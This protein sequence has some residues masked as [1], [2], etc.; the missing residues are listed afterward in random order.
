MRKG[1]S[2]CHILVI[3][4][5][6]RLTFFCKDHRD[7]VHIGDSGGNRD[8]ARFDRQNLIEFHIRKPAF[9]FFTDF[10]HQSNIDLMIQETVNFQNVAGL[11]NAIGKDLC[12]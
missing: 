3:G 9:D 11:D 1:I 7:F 5:V 10:F 2:L 6:H 8:S 4:A 12:F